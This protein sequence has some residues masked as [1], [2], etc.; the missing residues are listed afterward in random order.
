[1]SRAIPRTACFFNAT[2]PWKRNRFTSQS[3]VVAE[4]K[5]MFLGHS[6]S[7]LATTFAFSSL[8]LRDY[9]KRALDDI[10][11]TF[12]QGFL[13]YHI[14]SGKI[15]TFS[16]PVMSIY[17]LKAE[18]YRFSLGQVK[19]AKGKKVSGFRNILDDDSIIGHWYFEWWHRLDYGDQFDGKLWR[20]L[21]SIWWKRGVCV[22][23]IGMTGK[24]R[25][26]RK[27]GKCW[28]AYVAYVGIW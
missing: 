5:I 18:W 7:L 16:L 1:M 3:R 28:Y 4:K 20:T 24:K 9:E 11:I 22:G 17:I 10:W 2:W 12:Q 23:R 27:W 14:L 6:T 26:D 15:I 21:S 19:V 8:T 25:V 13:W